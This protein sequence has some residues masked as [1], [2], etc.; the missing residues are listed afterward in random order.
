MRSVAFFDG[1]PVLH[2]LDDLKPESPVRTNKKADFDLAAQAVA[3]LRDHLIGTSWVPGAQKYAY[4]AYAAGI[5]QAHEASQSVLD[6]LAAIPPTAPS[7]TA[8]TCV[9]ELA[10]Q[11]GQP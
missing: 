1:R 3:A 6:V 4:A 9:T 5:I 10:K 11:G 2:K 7:G 8:V